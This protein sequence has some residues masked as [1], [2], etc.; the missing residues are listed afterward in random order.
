MRWTSCKSGKSA[1]NPVEQFTNWSKV[2]KSGC[3]IYIYIDLCIYMNGIHV[4]LSLR[5][6]L[7]AYFGELVWGEGGGGGGG[8]GPFRKVQILNVSWCQTAPVGGKGLT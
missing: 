2:K 6:Q 8:E 4:Y 5:K 1:Y 7:Y 3:N